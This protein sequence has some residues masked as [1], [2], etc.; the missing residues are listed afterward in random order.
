MI[1]EAPPN[2]DSREPKTLAAKRRR[3]RRCSGLAFSQCSVFGLCFD[4]VEERGA[5]FY[6]LL[7]GKIAAVARQHDDVGRSKLRGHFDGRPER[8]FDFG[9]RLAAVQPFPAG[10]QTENEEVHVRNLGTSA[11]T[12]AAWQIS[13]D[14]GLNWLLDAIDGSVAPGKV[15]IVKRRFRGMPLPSVGGTLVLINPAGETLDTQVYGPSTIG[16]IIQF[17]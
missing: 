13:N 14:G 6:A 10:D 2:C 12:L 4:T 11:V 9:V 5:G 17:D 1:R 7:V 8:L 3:Y 15:A 16:Q